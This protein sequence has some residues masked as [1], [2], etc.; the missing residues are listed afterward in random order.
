MKKVTIE[1]ETV[2][3]AF[4]PY[5]YIELA[6]IMHFLGYAFE[7]LERPEIVRDRN[8]KTVGKITFE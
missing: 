8:G 2:N 7:G 4:H 3:N 1:I 5:L 6:K